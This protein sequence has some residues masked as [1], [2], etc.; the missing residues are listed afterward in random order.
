MK[1]IDTVKE[2]QIICQK[3]ID[4]KNKI[5][6]IPTMGNLHHGHE[7]LLKASMDDQY[8]ICSIFINPLQFDD[9]SDYQNYPKTIDSDVALLKSHKIDYLFLPNKNDIISDIHQISNYKLPSFANVLCGKY[10]ELHFLGVVKIVKKLFDIIQPSIAYFGKKDY[11]QLLLIKHLVNHHFNS[12]IQII[13]CETIR[14]KN[15]LAMSSRNSNLSPEKKEIAANIYHELCNLR[16]SIID[17]QDQLLSKKS[18]IIKRMSNL[19]IRI[20]YLEVLS[21]D[22][23]SVPVDIYDKTN[24]FVAFYV[25]QVRMIDNIEI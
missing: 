18:D 2:Q 15:G 24:I 16:E 9:M 14:E 7:S 11:Q 8:R 10:R 3:L 22:N 6:L 17:D 19:G 12:D 13:E 1:I 5:S 21:R 25:D 20:E 4:G 23:L